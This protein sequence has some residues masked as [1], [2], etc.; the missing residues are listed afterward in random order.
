V[1]FTGSFSHPKIEMRSRR[2]LPACPRGQEWSLA[3]GRLEFVAYAARSI[4]NDMSCSSFFLEEKR[5][6]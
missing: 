5:F 6:F 1:C 3:L 2:S 4:I